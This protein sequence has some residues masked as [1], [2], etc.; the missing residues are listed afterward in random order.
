M[1]CCT[2]WYK[3]VAFMH[4]DQISERYIFRTVQKYTNKYKRK[5]VKLRLPPDPGGLELFRVNLLAD[6][7][8]ER[9]LGHSK[10]REYWLLRGPRLFLVSALAVAANITYNE[11]LLQTQTRV[12]SIV[13]GSTLLLLSVYMLFMRLPDAIHASM[14]RVGH[15]HY[16]EWKNNIGLH[17]IT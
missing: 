1:K 7:E 8:R 14:M 2:K 3:R 15:T 11:V 13:Y 4:A 9:N 12:Y 17:H 10:A 6:L 5:R 16:R